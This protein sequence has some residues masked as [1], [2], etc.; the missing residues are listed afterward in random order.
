MRKERERGGCRVGIYICV[1]VCNSNGIFVNI[2]GYENKNRIFVNICGV[3]QSGADNI[4]PHPD[5]RVGA[6][7][8]TCNR[9]ATFTGRVRLGRFKIVIP[10]YTQYFPD[11]SLQK[12]FSEI[13]VATKM[14]PEPS[15]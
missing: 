6:N 7:F 8:L 1:C 5:L 13:I 14:T 2:C 4:R 11:I 12:F 10:K 15:K 3:G 9:P